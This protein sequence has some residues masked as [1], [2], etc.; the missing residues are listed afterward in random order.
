MLF[1]FFQERTY[2]NQTKRVFGFMKWEAILEGYTVLQRVASRCL[3]RSYFVSTT[4]LILLDR[5]AKKCVGFGPSCLPT[6][7]RRMLGECASCTG[8]QLG[9]ASPEMSA[10]SCLV[11]M[12]SDDCDEVIT[13]FL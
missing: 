11:H 12:T 13:I 8:P 3:P 2:F 4:D 10:L 6:R 9:K 5:A 7:C 1:S